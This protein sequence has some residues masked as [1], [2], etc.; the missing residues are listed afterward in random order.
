MV[1]TKRPAT[2][3]TTAYNETACNGRND[4]SDMVPSMNRFT[5]ALRRRLLLH[6]LL[7]TARGA[8]PSTTFHAT[9]GSYL[10]RGCAPP[11]PARD[12][13]RHLFL[14]DYIVIGAQKGGTETLSYELGALSLDGRRL[15]HARAEVHFFS[16]HHFMLH[17]IT[18]VDLQ[19]YAHTLES[20]VPSGCL[21]ATDRRLSLLGEKS[22]GYSF[23]SYAALRMCEALVSPRIFFLLRNPVTRAYS[24]FY[25]TRSD[26]RWMFPNISFDPDGFNRFVD[27]ETAIVQG[28][29]AS[30]VPIGDPR[31]DAIHSAQF[32]DCCSSI[33]RQ[34]F[35]L[36]SWNGC[37]YD[38]NDK[39][40]TMYGHARWL[41][42][43]MGI[44]VWQVRIL[45]RYHR[46]S[47]VLFALSEDFFG[48][49][50]LVI[51]ELLTWLMG[52]TAKASPSIPHTESTQLNS[53]T[54]GQM[55]HTTEQKLHRFYSP[56]NFELEQILGRPTNWEK[57][58]ND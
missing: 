51:K 50:D 44:Y 8:P 52:S 26:V 39:W 12:A 47:R 19:Q 48:N 57:Q 33:T 17:Q 41:R 31:L 14:P 46:T 16:S 54:Q 28:C 45:L 6:V 30:I 13:Y 27:V 22:P 4:P 3:E 11:S 43:R 56:Y 1:P 42:V 35:G 25:H 23:F 20:L 21:N 36:P 2:A 5:L 53:R 37:R 18:D 34:R 55:L 38:E 49:N 29:Q 24:A 9:N 15:C 40:S 32:R 10:Y 7:L 58:Y